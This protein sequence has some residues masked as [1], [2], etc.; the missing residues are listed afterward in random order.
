MSMQRTLPTIAA[1]AALCWAAPVWARPDASPVAGGPVL[2]PNSSPRLS[3][4]VTAVRRVRD[5]VVN[6][7]SERT[8]M[9][10]AS[11][12]LFALAPSQSRING[13]GTGILIDPRGYIITNHHVVEDVQLLR[14]RLADG[15]VAS[16]R[17]LAREPEADLA[18]LKIDVGRPLPTIPLGTS[19]DLLVAENVLAIGNAYGYEHTVT[20]GI[21]SALGRDVVLN[22]DVSYK[23]L[24]Q[25]DAPINPGNSGGPLINLQGELVGVNVAIR[26]GAQSI[27][28]AIPVDTMIRV[29]ATMLASR[30]AGRPGLAGHGLTVHDDVRRPSIEAP[31]VRQVVVDRADL[32]LA[33]GKAGLQGG[34]VLE[35]VGDTPILCSLDLERAL[36][37]HVPGDHL[38][39]IFRRGTT[40]RQADLVL[41]PGSSPGVEGDLVWRKL[42]LKLQ[43]A[44]TE[45]VT[46]NHPQLHGGLVVVDVRP[47][48]TAGKAGIQRGDILVG[49][50]DWEML[51]VENVLYV[52]NHPRLA[53]FGPLRYYVLRSGQVYRGVLNT[54]E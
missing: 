38:L 41:E 19:S 21:I 28:F 8:A 20:R 4:A 48:G 53:T 1:W 44:G 37:D 54:V 50:H 17:V 27:G 18:L 2:N 11:E 5:A 30:G 25:T 3:P 34:D 22:K 39:V 24:I 9:G 45:G 23:A 33:G 42:G 40:E 10:P 14:V 52:L 46:R 7:H 13:M 15:T 29:A 26:A 43:S 36:L 35:R 12:D 32:H 51:S 49:L 47:E 16:A 6:I 31:F